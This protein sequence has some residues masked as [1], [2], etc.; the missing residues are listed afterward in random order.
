MMDRL[1]HPGFPG[2]SREMRET[3][4]RAPV[5]RVEDMST[6]VPVTFRFPRA[7]APGAHQVAVVGPFNGWNPTTHLLTRGETT[8]RYTS[9]CCRAAPCTAFRLMARS[10][11][12]HT[13]RN[14]C[15]RAGSEYSVRYIRKPGP[16]MDGVKARG[17]Q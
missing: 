6:L 17:G 8:G 3:G 5:G 1:A 16:C 2:V 9:G 10:G 14:G 11:S 7:F 15:R 13:M 4:V 12:I